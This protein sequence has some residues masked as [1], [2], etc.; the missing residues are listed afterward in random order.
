[1]K[2]LPVGW[3]FVLKIEDAIDENGNPR[4]FPSYWK[5]YNRMSLKCSASYR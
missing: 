5:S 4:T 1:M 3:N 2:C